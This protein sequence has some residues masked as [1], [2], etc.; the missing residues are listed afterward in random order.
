MSLRVALIGDIH[1]D[2]DRLRAMLSDPA[3]T[4][5]E[6]VF[7]GDYVNRGPASREVIDEL[8]SVRRSHPEPTTFLVGNH[9]AA[10]CEV[11]RGGPVAPL[12]LMGGGATVRS[13]IREVSG[14]VAEALREAVSAEQRDFLFNLQDEWETTGV[15]ATHSSL[16]TVSDR[17]LHVV[18]HYI[19]ADCKPRLADGV[20]YLDT[21][22]G[23]RPGGT[24]SALLLPEAQFVSR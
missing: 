2:I 11:L 3:L 10:L 14:D 13:W 9:D 5:R 19:Q 12:L 1:G 16:P 20:A 7:L 24:L 6:L 23:S 22:C 15:R 4:G 17:R 21:G 8:V 18:G